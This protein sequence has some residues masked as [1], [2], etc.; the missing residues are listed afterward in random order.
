MSGVQLVITPGQ[1]GH[2]ARYFNGLAAHLADM[3]PLMDAVGLYLVGSAIERFGSESAPDGTPWKPSRRAQQEGGQ[4]LSLT[5]RLR[6]SLTRRAGAA[7][8]VVGS[9]VVY[10]GIHQFGG[11]IEPVDAKAL[12]FVI[13]GRHI[14]VQ[15]V[16]MPARPFLGINADDINE[17]ADLAIAFFEGAGDGAGQAPA[18]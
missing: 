6:S 18:P 2:A 7:E 16:T 17:I 8:V 5:G 10:A 14:I 13:G 3:T 4:T 12:H 1:L 9:N 11:V 15:R